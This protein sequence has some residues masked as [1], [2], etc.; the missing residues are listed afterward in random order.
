MT[1]ETMSAGR[2]AWY[3]L[4]GWGCVGLVYFSTGLAGGPAVLIPETAID[5]AIGYQRGA[6][7]LYLSFFILIP[8]TYLHAAPGRVRWLARSMQLSALAAGISFV[9]YP[10]T[11]AYPPAGGGEGAGAAMLA[12]LLAGDSPR[13]CLPS[14]HGSLTLL[15]VWALIERG[16]PGR[17]LLAV[18]AGLAIA[19]S[20]IALRRHL[21]IDLSAGMASGLLCGAVAAWSLR[22]ES[23]AP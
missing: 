13:N 12:L 11:L 20:V 8:Y 22:R 21:W 16:R 9:L 5:R 14:L 4:L 19:W 15:C 23:A 2:R 7:W 10:T 18:A 3:G 6:I 17:S 1:G